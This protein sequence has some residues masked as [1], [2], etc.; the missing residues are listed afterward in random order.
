MKTKESQ[1]GVSSEVGGTC[2]HLFSAQGRR[3]A[4]EKRKVEGSLRVLVARR[5]GIKTCN[6]ACLSV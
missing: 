4:T 2:R 3:I 1:L 6:R 5:R